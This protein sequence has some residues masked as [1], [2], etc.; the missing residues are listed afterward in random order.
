MPSEYIDLA[1]KMGVSVERFGVEEGLNNA[2]T[3][4]KKVVLGKKLMEKTEAKHLLAIVVH[5]LGHIKGRH[6]IKTLVMLFLLFI[7][8]IP[9]SSL[10]P[11][12]FWIT[13]MVYFNITL[14]PVCW[15][16]AFDA[17]RLAAEYV[18]I[19]DVKEALLAISGKNIDEPC[20][21]HPSIAERIKNLNN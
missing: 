1:G 10:P 16:M 17:D 14:I 9:L 5:E 12:M 11:L 20:E 8:I 21:T 3:I 19:E 15:K 2:Y 18:G 7:S 4:G 6:Q 13:V